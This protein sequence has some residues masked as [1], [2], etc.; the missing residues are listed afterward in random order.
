[1]H[2][3]LAIPASKPDSRQ[4][5]RPAQL[6]CHPVRE[7][8]PFGLDRDSL[9]PAVLRRLQVL[10]VNRADRA[11]LS[12]ARWSTVRYLLGRFEAGLICA[13]RGRLRDQSNL[14]SKRTQIRAEKELAALGVA[15]TTRH[16]SPGARKSNPNSFRSARVLAR[17]R[18]VGRLI[19]RT[20]AQREYRDDVAGR[21]ASG[22]TALD[23][24]LA[25]GFWDAWVARA[26]Y[27]RELPDCDPD[28][29]STSRP[30]RR[31]ASQIPSEQK[32]AQDIA[33]LEVRRAA[34]GTS[35]TSD[36]FATQVL[37]TKKP[38]IGP[39]CGTAAQGRSARP[40][41][42]DLGVPLPSSSPPRVPTE[43]LACRVHWA[44]CEGRMAPEGHRGT[45]AWSSALSVAQPPRS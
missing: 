8:A 4:Q 19:R 37:R 22:A 26:S 16:R 32:R 30:R 13:T 3:H 36:P 25:T 38:L 43:I 11:A 7:K 39:L 14:G 33:G 24:S 2:N 12:T 27:D 1:V 23:P 15:V 28:R 35:E 44:S 17:W 9:W 34:W 10:G 31:M 18:R 40:P 29:R 41:A 42:P 6:R 5:P 21:P 20:E 45:E